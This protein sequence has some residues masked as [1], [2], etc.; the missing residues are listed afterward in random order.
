M[1][2][3]VSRRDALLGAGAAVAALSVRTPALA[4][5]TVVHVSTVGIFGAAP[6]YA[7][8]A[9]GYFTA[10]N[11]AV[12]TEAVQSG[13]VGVPALAIGQFDILY[14]NTVSTISAIDHSIDL[15]IVFGG[16]TNGPKPP[17][18]SALMKRRGDAL[19]TGRDLEGKVVGVNGVNGINWVLT[20]SWVKM[21]GGDP[22]RVK[23]LELP[24]AALIAAIKAD[25]IDAAYVVD[26]F[27]TIGSTD[28]ALESFAWPQSSVFAGGQNGLWVAMGQTIAQRPELVRAFVR[29]MRKGVTWI[30][31][32]LGSDSYNKLVAGFTK[33]DPG[34]LAKMQ[35]VPFGMTVTAAQIQP[36]VRL[37]REN[38]LL[39]ADIDLRPRMFN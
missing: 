31:A 5:P 19:R 34:L 6:F 2:L 16:G 1:R 24:N 23:F 27:M 8:D 12:T 4:D 29:A 11:L 36:M 22:D 13:A 14:A 17:G 7:A 26:P 28:P 3:H 37:M 10:E 20:R 18:N 30:N 33:I 32:N 38:G 35:M 15:R 39:T 9:Q 25:R 21:T